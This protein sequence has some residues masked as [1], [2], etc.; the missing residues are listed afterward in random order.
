MRGERAGEHR[1]ESLDV[2]RRAQEREGERERREGTRRSA[3]VNEKQ[4]LRLPSLAE[5]E[6]GATVS[7]ETFLSRRIL[8]CPSSNEHV[9][10]RFTTTKS[11]LALTLHLPL[12]LLRVYVRFLRFAGDRH[13]GTSRIVRYS[14]YG[15]PGD[16]GLRYLIPRYMPSNSSHPEPSHTDSIDHS[17]SRSRAWNSAQSPGIIMR[18]TMKVQESCLHNFPESRIFQFIT[19]FLNLLFHHMNC[20]ARL[21]KGLY[22]TN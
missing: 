7:V 5:R 14:R 9:S 17:N 2:L 21:L 16:L 11:L 12:L 22:L 6:N 3:Q 15:S 8:Q 1:L 19:A 20:V 4:I 13:V 18:S 10:T